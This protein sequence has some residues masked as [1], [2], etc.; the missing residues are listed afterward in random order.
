MRTRSTL[1]TALIV[2]ATPHYSPSQVPAQRVAVIPSSIKVTADASG[3][4]TY[5]GLVSNSG[6]QA[7]CE[8]SVTIA[9]ID[10]S[11]L[12][13]LNVSSSSVDGLRL[14]KSGIGNC[15]RPGD[16]GPFVVYTAPQNF[17]GCIFCSG[18][19]GK[20]VPAELGSSA[21]HVSWKPLAPGE[22]EVRPEDLIVE[23][24]DEASA[25]NTKALVGSVTNHNA[26]HPVNG[27]SVSFV[28][29][30]VAGKVVDMQRNYI[31]GPLAPGDRAAL[32]V[33]TSQVYNNVFYIVSCYW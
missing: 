21:Y 12:E 3:M 10:K 5:L 26:T 33:T 13:L 29:L 25:D 17:L 4:V 2:S 6:N 15:L 14:R 1:I 28:F 20:V 30:D 9:S 24:H 23:W 11:G 19:E 7:V 8:V 16:R 27:I 22:S 31:I 32:R 18:V